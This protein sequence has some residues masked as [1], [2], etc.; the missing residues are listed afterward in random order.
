MPSVFFMSIF[1]YFKTFSFIGFYQIFVLSSEKDVP[2]YANVIDFSWTTC[3]ICM[4]YITRFLS[5]QSQYVVHCQVDEV[6][7]FELLLVIMFN[8][9]SKVNFELIVLCVFCYQVLICLTLCCNTLSYLS[10]SI[11]QQEKAD[12]VHHIASYNHQ[13]K[14]KI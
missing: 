5:S 11:T 7:S 8:N 10:F 9:F 1:V 14:Q 3:V 12:F 2:L 4:Y 6:I 13:P